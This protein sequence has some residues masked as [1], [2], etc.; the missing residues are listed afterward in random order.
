MCVCL[1]FFRLS[2]VWSVLTTLDVEGPRKTEYI[3]LHLDFFGCWS[4]TVVR[5]WFFRSCPRVREIGFFG[6]FLSLSDR[7]IFGHPVVSEI[8]F[9]VHQGDSEYSHFWFAA[10][11]TSGPTL[12]H[13]V[14]EERGDLPQSLSAPSVPILE[15]GSRYFRGEV[16]QWSLIHS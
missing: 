16:S 15:V 7:C 6:G 11:G 5:V 12:L 4:F 9:L 1:W 10:R 3:G 8:R 2:S 14:G 13:E